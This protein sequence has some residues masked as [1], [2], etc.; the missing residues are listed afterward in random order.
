MGKTNKI[1]YSISGKTSPIFLY[2]F[3]FGLPF[4]FGAPSPDKGAF[5]LNSN[6]KYLNLN[7]SNKIFT[8]VVKLSSTLVYNGVNVQNKLKISTDVD[9]AAT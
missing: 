3:V 5:I 8:S 1:V 6:G 2:P 7:H 9:K 4:Y